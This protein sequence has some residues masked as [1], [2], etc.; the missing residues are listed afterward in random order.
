MA[1]VG[2][3]GVIVGAALGL[4]FCFVAFPFAISS[5]YQFRALSARI[6]DGQ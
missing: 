5:C 6:E 4:V 2:S 1:W 3:G